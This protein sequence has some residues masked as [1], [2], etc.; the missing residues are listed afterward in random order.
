[1]EIEAL[2]TN[3]LAEFADTIQCI[4]NMGLFREVENTKIDL[5]NL[6]NAKVCVTKHHLYFNWIIESRKIL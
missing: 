6:C 5:D 3:T 2:G 4:S 1:M